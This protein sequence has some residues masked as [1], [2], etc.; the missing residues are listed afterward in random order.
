MEE[1]VSVIIPVHNVEKYLNRCL[2]SVTSQTYHNLEIILVDDGSK[3][4]SP[5]L[6]DRWKEKDSRVTV[7]HKK[8]GGLSSARNLGLMTVSG[9]YVCFVDSDDWISKDYV[10][11]L[12]NLLKKNKADVSYCDFDRVNGE[13][14]DEKNIKKIEI[15]DNEKLMR[16]FFRVDGSK[17]SYAVW[18]GLYATELLKG[19]KFIEG[20]ITEDV[21][22]TYEIYK[23]TNKA[24]FTNE[25]LYH[26][27]VNNKGISCSA[28]SNRDLVLF[29]IWENI[30]NDVPDRYRYWAE[31]N[32][33]RVYFTLYVK[34]MVHGIDANNFDIGL[35]TRWQKE[36]KK[37]VKELRNGKM[38]DW[39]RKI[40]LLYIAYFK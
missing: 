28:L 24:V 34:G 14:S 26:Y 31:L 19:I 38:L 11:V 21:P 23:Q 37:N 40:L 32:R 16:L 3:D 15:L 9:K 5:S 8:N 1:L 17:S 20:I 18:R 27:F 35:L 36:I 2:R 12:Y 30:V 6:C 29:D 22:F 25:K 13:G 39:K 10:S 7:H 33:K 4:N